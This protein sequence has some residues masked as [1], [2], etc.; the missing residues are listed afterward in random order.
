M[1]TTRNYKQ[2]QRHCWSPQFINHYTLS[3]LQSVVPLLVVAWKQLSTTEILQLLCSD[4]YC[5]ANIRQLVAPSLPCLL[6]RT[7]LTYSKFKVTLRL[8]VYCQAVGL[9]VKPPETH[10][11]TCFFIWILAVSLYATSSDKMRLSLRNTL[12]LLHS[13]STG[14][15]E[16]IMLI[17]RILC[18]NGSLVTWTDVS[19]SATKFKPLIF[20]LASPCPVLRTCSFSWFCMTSACCLHNFVT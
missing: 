16:Q 1:N 17:L 6:C 5:P 4:P 14:F 11:Q 19:L 12:G 15:T 10:D 18:Y 8:A 13:V 20:S 3:P 7:E 9:G 2:L